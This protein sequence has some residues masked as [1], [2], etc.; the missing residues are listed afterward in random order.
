MIT[1]IIVAII[2]FICVTTG[3]ILLPKLPVPFLV[4]RGRGHIRIWT[5]E[6][7]A[8]NF[9]VILTRAEAKTD[10]FTEPFKCVCAALRRRE[11][12]LSLK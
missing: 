6:L 2:V 8:G 3:A 12:T 1:I 11:C 9:H 10:E 7:P 4:M 5:W